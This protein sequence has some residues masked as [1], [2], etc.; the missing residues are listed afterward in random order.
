ME[1]SPMILNCLMYHLYMSD[2]SFINKLILSQLQN[3][4]FI[5]VVLEKAITL[6]IHS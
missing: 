5:Y 1:F 4:H 6:N 3:S 2:G